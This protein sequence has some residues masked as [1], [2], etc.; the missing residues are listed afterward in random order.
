[1]NPT[2]PLLWSMLTIIVI[3]LIT[4]GISYVVTRKRAKCI[5]EYEDYV[6]SMKRHSYSSIIYSTV[7]SKCKLCGHIKDKP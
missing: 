6:L 3:G 2:E 4:I 5:H 1:M 7:I